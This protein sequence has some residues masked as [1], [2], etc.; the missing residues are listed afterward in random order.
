MSANLSVQLEKKSEA[1]KTKE[2]LA[3]IEDALRK[4]ALVGNF[5]KFHD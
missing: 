4:R 1:D 3:H 2:H 5:F